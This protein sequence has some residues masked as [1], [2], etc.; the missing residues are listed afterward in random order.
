MDAKN[1]L[2]H[3]LI[4]GIFSLAAAAGFT[5]F[6]DIRWSTAFA[7]VS[8]ILLFL[9]LMIGPM[10][11]LQKSNNGSSFLRKILAWRGELGIWFT[12]TALVH[13]YFA[14]ARR[15]R[16]LLT[17][18]GGGIG[19]GGYGLANLLGFIAL[20]WAIILTITSCGKVVK[21]LG[22]RSWKW[23]HSFCYVIFYLVVGHALYFQFFSDYG[24]GPDFF[25]WMYLVMTVLIILLQLGTFFKVM[26]KQKSSV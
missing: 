3:H 20:F 2:L 14:F 15:G 26:A 25:G 8:F 22:S 11:R 23:V 16:N 4:V 10:I 9:V 24:G 6:L 1:T 12:V 17:M 13:F 5:Q 18:L 19:G 21:F 7:R